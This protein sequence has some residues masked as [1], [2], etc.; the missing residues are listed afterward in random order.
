MIKKSFA[1]GL[2]TFLLS[3]L[4][5]SQ[6]NLG[7]LQSNSVR[8]AGN[9]GTRIDTLMIN[10]KINCGSALTRFTLVAKP[11]LPTIDTTG[12]IPQN[13]DSIEMLLSFQLPT[14]FVADSMWLW[15]DGKP[16][17]GKIQD[18]A[19]AAGQYQQIVGTRRDPA[20]LEF[21]GNGYFNLRI[22]PAELLRA[23][24]IE[25][26]FHHTFDDDSADAITASLPFSFD[27]SANYRSY[28]SYSQIGLVS[29]RFSSEDN[30]NYNVDFPGVGS[31]TF[32]NSQSLV[33]SSTNVKMIKPGI[34][35]R[36]DPSGSNDFLWIAKDSYRNKVSA[37]ITAQI[38]D[39]SVEFENEPQ[40][41]IIAIDI[42]NHTW[43][44]NDYYSSQ[45]KYLGNPYSN[46]SN[47]QSYD[48]LARAQKYA[49]LCMENYLKEGQKFNIVIGGK[50]VTTLFSEPVPTHS[51]YIKKAI[52]AILKLTPDGLSSTK[53]VMDEAVKQASSGIVI[54]I[55]DLFEPYNYYDN[56]KYPEI[57]VESDAGA[58]YEAS[59]RY[60]NALVD[61]S[62]ITL[63]TIDDNYRISQI[64]YETGGYRLGGILNRYNIEF[65]YEIVEGHRLTIPIMPPLFGSR[66]NSGIRDINITSDKLQDIVFTT[67]GY[68]YNWF[69]KDFAIARPVYSASAKLALP[70]SNYNQ[71]NVL[72]RIAGQAEL[73]DGSLV[74]FTL[75][76][77]IGG[78]KFK[79]VITA[80][81]NW[82]AAN[83]IGGVQ[84]AFRNSEA[85]SGTDYYEKSN[86]IKVIGKQYHIVTRQTSLL[87]LEP[88]MQLLE[89]TIYSSQNVNIK[90]ASPSLRPDE[91]MND[92]L[93]SNSYGAPT[94]SS[95]TGIDLD[96]ISLKE[97]AG[98]HGIT[99]V[100]NNKTN[101]KNNSGFAVRA[102]NRMINIR[103][104][105]VKGEVQLKLF[106]LK[107]R[108][109]L[110][111][112]L[113]ANDLGGFSYT[114]DTESAAF[115]IS[116]GFYMLHI[117]AGTQDKVYRIPLM[118]R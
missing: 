38:A 3:S 8:T 59:I 42:R 77:K 104:P 60:I 39:S 72:L 90:V 1:A 89:D 82:N 19:L 113:T 32:S 94:A 86:A 41:R 13:P 117:T 16:V 84:W 76:G 57:Y 17:E 2:M 83:N 18:R 69:A 36:N 81:N 10:T 5:F 43:N 52:E 98:M 34:I 31:G 58:I 109:V 24:K 101:N 116:K 112:K 108:V 54:L 45:A 103:I 66:N 93:W 25:I 4:S 87:A 21:S 78:L 14:D 110:H 114:W 51:E 63:F 37:G 30:G 53:M 29:A 6:I 20:L 28:L 95:G 105:D 44:W 74:T 80:E 71:E 50:T 100:I 9:A 11:F 73:L 70:Y 40:T 49:I 64:S 12:P 75:E 48:V 79:K 91:V 15:I 67:D 35:Y 22:F 23:R 111:K 61:T 99:P 62:D 107:G 97:L 68:S 118:G 46:T 7:Y 55:S 92:M 27:S 115:R 85:L 56:S 65:K 47:Y 102:S 88:G 106:D 26:Q 96:G 33:L